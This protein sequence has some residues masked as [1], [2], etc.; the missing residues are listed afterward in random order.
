[1]ALILSMQLTLLETFQ[2]LQVMRSQ[3]IQLHLMPQQHLFLLQQV[4]PVHLA[5]MESHRCKLWYLPELQSLPQLFSYI[6]TE[7][8]LE[9]LVQQMP[10]PVHL[11]APRDYWLQ[12]T[13]TDNTTVQLTPLTQLLRRQLMLFQILQM[14]LQELLY[15]SIPQNGH[16]S[17]IPLTC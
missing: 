17:Y 7:L 16:Q 3:S 15:W 6:R 2:Q 14:H 11:V 5:L 1:M 12:T 13:R 10:S 4:I 8:Q 9:V